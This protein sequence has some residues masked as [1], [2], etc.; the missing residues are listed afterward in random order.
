MPMT[1]DELISK[2]KPIQMPVLEGSQYSRYNKVFK[3]RLMMKTY[4]QVAEAIGL[5]MTSVRH[6][7]TRIVWHRK[8]ILA[9]L[10]TALYA[11][12]TPG[13]S[14]RIVKNLEEAQWVATDAFEGVWLHYGPGEDEDDQFL[15]YSYPDETSKL[16]RL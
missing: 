12:V 16:V 14:D 3:L 10:E 5:H 1:I 8:A 15:G 13:V 9:R 4:G 7:I 2:A 11:N 6:K